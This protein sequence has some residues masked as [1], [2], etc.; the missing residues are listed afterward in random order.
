MLKKPIN[1]VFK[2]VV[3]LPYYSFIL[4][5]LIIS[6]PLFLIYI[7]FIIKFV[8]VFG[9][10]LVF[11]S[12]F[13]LVLFLLKKK[14]K[15]IA[16]TVNNE[17]IKIDGDIYNIKDINKIYCRDYRRKVTSIITFQF[18]LKTEKQLKLQI[19]NTKLSIMRE[20]GIRWLTF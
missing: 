1:F 12:T 13:G 17:T 10:L 2:K 5:T 15:T 7:F 4:L 6:V 20:R 9:I 18:I 14:S 16:I 11:L 3:T 8:G 19:Q